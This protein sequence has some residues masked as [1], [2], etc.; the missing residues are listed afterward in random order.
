VANR[1]FLIEVT[2]DRIN[3]F[4]ATAITDGDIYF[5]PIIANGL[6][7]AELFF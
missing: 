3:D 5:D 1:L 2:L 6:E 7:R 4:A